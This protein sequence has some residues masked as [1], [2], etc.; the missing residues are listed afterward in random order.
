MMYRKVSS[1]ETASHYV[2]AKYITYLQTTQSS[3]LDF[4]ATVIK[5]NMLANSIFLTDPGTYQRKFNNTS[6]YFDTSLVIFALGYAGEPRKWPVLELINLLKKHNAELKIFRHSLEE[7]IGILAA[8]AEVFRTRS[9]E[10]SYGPSVE[11]FIESGYSETDIMMFLSNLESDIGN[12]GIEIIEKPS[13]DEFTNVIDENAYYEYL[14]EF[15]NYKRGLALERDVDSIA[16]IVRLRKGHRYIQ[17]ENCEALFVTANK[18]LA[19]SSRN[20]SDFNF[21]GGTAPIAMTDYELTNLVWLKDPSLSSSLPRRRLIAISYA[22][23]QPADVLWRKYLETIKALEIEGKITNDQYFLLRHS[24]QAKSELM[25]RTRGVDDIFTAGTIDEILNRIEQNIRAEDISKL[26]D[27]IREKQDVLQMYEDEHAALVN[28]EEEIKRKN[29]EKEE[30]I[31]KRALKI[32]KVILATF[33]GLLALALGY[34]TFAISPI[35]PLNIDII[36]TM[37]K[38]WQCVGLSIFWLLLLA[39]ILSTN[40]GIGPKKLK[41][42]SEPMLQKKIKKVLERLVS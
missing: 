10:D 35:G 38:I 4:M 41:D 33:S 11:Y 16:A 32:S 9:F 13:Y 24:I 21:Q 27:E 22:C 17:I 42:Y 36:N 3:E 12:L 31:D 15:M 2:I 25:E 20:F 37:P 40:F 30:R 1:E 5:G 14:K 19:N 18:A 26:N 28:L 6:I 7:I 34:L 23:I 39:E 8:C 29:R